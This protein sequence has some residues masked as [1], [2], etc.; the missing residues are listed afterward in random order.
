[1][2]S[3]TPNMGDLVQ[4]VVVGWWRRRRAYR[5]RCSATARVQDSGGKS[6]STRH[7]RCWPLLIIWA[8][9]LQSASITDTGSYWRKLS[10]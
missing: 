1:M 2:R 7:C 10:H 4:V 9:S 8:N 6:G 3:L 5:Y